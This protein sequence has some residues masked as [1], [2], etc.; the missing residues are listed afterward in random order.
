MQDSIPEP[1]DHALNQKAYSQL[2]SHPGVPLFTFLNV[3]MGKLKITC[4]LCIGYF[5]NLHISHKFSNAKKAGSL[6]CDL[7]WADF[8]APWTHQ[9][10]CLVLTD[11][12]DMHH[13]GRA[14]GPH[15]TQGVPGGA[16]EPGTVY[17]HRDS[18]FVGVPVGAKER[19][20]V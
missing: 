1:Q 12:G 16:G 11:E 9:G 17:F 6:R 8:S 18:Y 15:S 20:P 14:M 5:E 3:P 19:Q 13:P 4:V 7:C 2:L 10:A